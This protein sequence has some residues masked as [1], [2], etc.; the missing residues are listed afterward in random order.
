MRTFLLAKKK[1]PAFRT[2]NL[3]SE[4]QLAGSLSRYGC[5]SQNE[6]R[7]ITGMLATCTALIILE[8]TVVRSNR[9]LMTMRSNRCEGGF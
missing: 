6:G 7:K 3:A 1:R 2:L 4:P 5:L 9:G 8:P